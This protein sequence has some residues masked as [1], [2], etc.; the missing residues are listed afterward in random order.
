MR[1][2]LMKTKSFSMILITKKHVKRKP[3]IIEGALSGVKLI[4]E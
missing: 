2:G 1:D 4:Q 3:K